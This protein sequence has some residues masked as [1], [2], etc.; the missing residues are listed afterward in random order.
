MNN[1]LSV[2][3]VVYIYEKAEKEVKR[4]K[5]KLKSLFDYQR[6]QGNKRLDKMIS[7]AEND[8][9]CKLSDDDLFQ[10]S[11]AGEPIISKKEDVS[12]DS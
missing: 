12:Y 3:S 7:E 11:A 4:M 2:F 9:A 8:I 1:I 6:F 5:N 10:V